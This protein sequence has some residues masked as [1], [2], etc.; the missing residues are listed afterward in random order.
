MAQL[1]R[2]ADLDQI[3]WPEGPAP[4]EVGWDGQPVRRPAVGPDGEDLPPWAGLPVGPRRPGRT[5]HPQRGRAEPAP[6]EAEPEPGPDGGDGGA[7]GGGLTRRAIA[8]RARKARRKLMIG[9]GAAI[10]AVFIA[11]GVWL[12]VRPHAAA[13]RGPGFVSTFQP[14]EFRSVPDACQALPTPV[15]SQYLPGHPTRVHSANVGGDTSSQCTWTLDAKPV[16]RVLQVTQEAF[17]PS[18]LNTGN[19]SA[20][21]GAIDGF[22][23]ARVQ[24]ASPA[25]RTHLPPATVTSVPG[26]GDNA[27]SAV[28]VIHRGGN[29]NDLVTLVVRDHNV[30]LT[31][32]F[33]GEQHAAAGGYGPVSLSELK[34]GTLAAARAALAGLTR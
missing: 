18:G 11:A 13:H 21:F 34:A 15:L 3:V 27:F 33:Q 32:S 29:V 7:G 2:S 25:K 4:A 14:G 28:Q 22:S 24:L 10:V 16:Y 26:L 23:A 6:A 31:V 9:G 20:T 12:L 17:T 5:I 1:A 8:T 19:G 30:L